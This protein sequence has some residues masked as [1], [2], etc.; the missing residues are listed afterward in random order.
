MRGREAI[1]GATLVGAGVG[2]PTTR[3]VGRSFGHLGPSPVPVD[4]ARGRGAGNHIPSPEKPRGGQT[5][6]R[7]WAEYFP[8][9]DF[10]PSLVG[11]FRL[12]YHKRP[13]DWLFRREIFPSIFQ[14]IIPSQPCNF[15]SHYIS[16]GVGNGEKSGLWTSSF[17]GWMKG[18]F[19]PRGGGVV[20]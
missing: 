20:C 17:R 4:A 14:S 11:N 7:S 19:L 2:D 16:A 9:G 18:P 5:S 15:Y 6:S 12:L 8:S 10:H 3:G 13:I 1:L